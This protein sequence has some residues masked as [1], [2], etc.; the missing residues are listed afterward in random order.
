MIPW[1]ACIPAGSSVQGILQA[2]GYWSV[3]PFPS[4]G[5]LPDPGIEPRSPALQADSL[6]F[7][8]GGKYC[9]FLG[10][11]RYKI[12]TLKQGSPTFL[13]PGACLIEG[14]F[15]T[16]GIRGWFQDD[17]TAAVGISSKYR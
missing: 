1:T 2:K 6:L 12:D 11:M 4:P 13:A 3:L 17:S 15:S 16:D 5:D 14:N 10:R 9:I 8:P 7:E